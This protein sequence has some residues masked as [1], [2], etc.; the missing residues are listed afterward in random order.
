MA[1]THAGYVA[2]CY[3]VGLF[4]VVAFAAYAI[5]FGAWFQRRRMRIADTE[6]FTT[7]RATQ[8]LWRIGWSFF[9][10]A[11]G[12]WALVTPANF[13]S[14]GGIVGVV[15]YAL[16]TGLP[17]LLFAFAGEK[18]TAGLP[19]VYSLADFI[20]W[21]FG[22]IAKTLVALI[23]LFNMCVVLLAEYTTIGSIFKDFVGTVDW[24][25]ILAVALVTIAYTS[26]G[27]LVVSIATDQLQGIAAFLLMVVVAIF[28]G[29]NYR[30]RGVPPMA[31]L[32]PELR[33]SFA[34]WTSIF[35]LGA[36][37]TGCYIFSEA[38]W[39]RVW[40]S[41]DRRALRGGATIGFALTTAFIFFLGFGGWL[42]LAWGLA[43]PDTN[44]NLYFFQL[45]GGRRNAFVSNWVGV[46]AV[47]LA[48]VVNEGAVDTFQ[49]GIAASLGAQFFKAR[50]LWWSR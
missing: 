5:A 20:G 9:C 27:G 11:V 29:V 3:A 21:R 14:Y 33:P 1:L 48:V 41:E 23:A 35:T 39:Q 46:L 31:A 24:A 36:S 28:V 26:Y 45:L 17:I 44:P 8:P 37:L 30:G 18:I 12:S 50:P 15:A 43:G 13:A 19:H 22:P 47:L 16:A 2:V 42:A 10:G 25:F 6:A 32:A 34:G 38:L 40:A 49:N 4:L 7:A